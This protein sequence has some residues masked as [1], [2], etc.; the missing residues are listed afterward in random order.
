MVD[1]HC[2]SCYSFLDGA[3]HPEELVQRA[4]ELGYTALALT[5]HNG[6]YGSLEFAQAALQAGLQPITGAEVTLEDEAHLTLLAETPEGY[7]N[8]CRLL[9]TAHRAGER[10]F[11]RLP[12]AALPEHAKGLIALSGCREGEIPRLLA[13]GQA[14]E[15]ER[16]AERYRAWFGPEGFF[17]EL[18]DNLVRGDTARCRALAALGERTGIP[19]VATNNTHYHVR[20]RHR[21]Q[22]TL[23][24][25]REGATLFEARRQRRQ[26]SDFALKTAEAFRARFRQ[27][28]GAVANALR[29]AERCRSFDLTRDLGYKFPAFLSEAS[30]DQFR[31]PDEA[32]RLL[33]LE[34]LRAKYGGETQER[35]E[36]AKRWLEEELRLV[37]MHGLAGFFLVYRD[38]LQMSKQVA[39]ELRGTGAR[40]RFELPPGRGRGS[41][42]S[43]I[44]CYLIG[45]SCVDPVK[46]KLF[47]GRF[48]NESLSSVPDIDID[49]P[50]DIRAELI[51][52]VHQ[53]YGEDHAALVCIFP[54]YRFRGA[55]R[56]IGKAL[57]LP[58][59]D[60]DRLAK[61]G[62]GY[63]QVRGEV[64]RLRE[65]AT[66]T[67]QA[68]WSYLCDLAEQLWGMPRHLSQH[69]GGMVISSRPLVE[70]VPVERSAIEGR[71]LVQWDKDSVDAAR[72][73]KVDFLALGMLSAVEEC[74]ELV[75][76]NGKAPVDLSRI[77]YTDPAVY[78]RICRG[79]TVGAFQIESRAQIGMVVRTRPRTIEDLAVQVAIV[80]PGPI[81]GNA[82]NPYV[83][84]REQQRRNR[85]FKPQCDHPLLEPVL[86]DTLGVII[87]QDQVMEACK[88]LAGFTDGEADQLRRAMSRKRSREAIEKFRELFTEG[89]A[90]RGVPPEVAC[91]VFEKVVAFSEFGFPKSHSAAF[92]ILAY[93]SVWLM[94]YH[95][96]EFV[97]ALIN[98]QPM[99][100]YGP[101]TLIKDAQRRGVRFLGP[102]LNESALG[103]TV[104]RRTVQLGLKDVD[105]LGEIR[106]R[107]I[108]A[109]R[110][111]H[112]AYLSLM[113]FLRRTRQPERVAERLILVGALDGF[114]MNRREL[115]WQLGLLEAYREH[116]IGRVM[117]DASAPASRPV[118]QPSL[119]LPTAQDEV[120]LPP[121]G[122][123]EQMAREYQHMGLS[124][125]GHPLSLLRPFLTAATW[126]V[127]DLRRCPD[128]A[129]ITV[130]GLVTTRQRPGTAKGILF[131]LVED[132]TG[133]LN[134][135]VKPELYEAQ[136]EL[137]RSEPLLAV[138]GILERRE[139][140]LNLVAEEAWPLTDFLP[141]AVKSAAGRR[142]HE[143]VQGFQ[144]PASHNYR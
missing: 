54:T 120:A 26:N 52:R 45:L 71:Q 143:A 87:F 126:R 30:D 91:R 76:A 3:S 44:I 70:M 137:Y 84:Q 47:P 72:M 25:I 41:A 144:A 104:D 55:V 123:W 124:V 66:C 115:L 80:R 101:D 121:A 56:E 99:G 37:A 12:Y 116:A 38:L 131:L 113:D 48:L 69:V 95:P 93:Q 60:L 2:H 73:I 39:A 36:E 125:E 82:V 49:F 118:Y 21:L 6:V 103:C 89:A 50:R 24:A 102:D 53:H 97:A 122:R 57:A 77:P 85:D 29:I 5:D 61:L 51:K 42:V 130:A 13:M 98:N 8:L 133:M 64:T 134:I 88:A 128:K 138:S 141:D 107:E 132:E 46:A 7:A 15:A 96:T 65:F 100:F 74:L 35:Q 14:G 59:A 1:L 20:E 31:T 18:Q 86:S 127:R 34:A 140:R 117:G 4:V 92:A 16:V 139:R 90:G 105:G 68:G 23:V 111:A 119:W 109:E 108:L 11:P 110:Q 27:Y 106:A 28:P 17:L 75:T 10:R 114:G 142:A 62:D 33:C 129:R 63:S 135:V 79:E 78:N 67:Q 94:H 58:P 22:D 83:R 136:R 81:V 112:G 19:Q 43:S 32:L 40:G 9:T